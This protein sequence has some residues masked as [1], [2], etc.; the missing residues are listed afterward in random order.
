MLPIL[1]LESKLIFDIVQIV[2]MLLI[3][4]YTWFQE[5]HARVYLCYRTNC[6]LRNKILR[7]RLESLR[8]AIYDWVDLRW[9]ELPALPTSCSFAVEANQ[10]LKN[11]VVL[12]SPVLFDPNRIP[13]LFWYPL[14]F[15]PS[16]LLL[17]RRTRKMSSKVKVPDALS[18]L[19][20]M[21]TQ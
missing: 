15:N 19:D 20:E 14:R 7:Q 8:C 12:R 4:R 18:S 13:S 11:N 9:S 16:N 5:T 2:L 1:L 10:L 17:T 3:S 6:E 21:P